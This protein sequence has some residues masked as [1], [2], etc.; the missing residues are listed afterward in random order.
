MTMF[1]YQCQQTAGGTGCREQGVCG[2]DAKTAALQDLLTGW[3]KQIA[4]KR[5]EYRQN[6][7]SSRVVDKFLLEALYVTLTNVN[8]DPKEI[9]RLI[10]LAGQVAQVADYLVTG[11]SAADQRNLEGQL[12]EQDYVPSDQEVDELVEQGLAFSLTY[13]LDD[14][15]PVITGLQEL[16]LYGIRGTAAYT[17]HFYN[18]GHEARESLRLETEGTKLRIKEIRS[19]TADEKRRKDALQKEVKANEEAINEWE[20]KETALLDSLF[21]ELAAVDTLTDREA[22]LASALKIGSLNLNAMELLEQLH[23]SRFDVPWMTAVQTNPVPGK[24]ILVSGHDL[25][26]LYEL[27]VQTKGKEINVYTHGEMLPAHSY[28]GLKKF[29]HLVGHFGTAWQNQRDEFDS[30]PGAILMTSNCIQKPRESYQDYIFTTGPVAWPGVQHISA[31]KNGKKNFSPVIQAALDSPGFF[32]KSGDKEKLT[33]GYGAD[34]VKQIKDKIYRAVERG[35]LRR[36]FVIAGCDGAQEKRNYFTELAEA[37]PEDC[38]ILTCGCGKYRFNSIKFKPMA[39]ATPR[40]WDAGQCNDSW[41]IIRIL[42]DLS[43]EFGKNL[44]DLPVSIFLS[45]YEQKAVAVLLSLLSLNIRNIHIGP[46]VPAFLSP[47]I[48]ALLSENYG[49]KLVSEDPRADLDAVLKSEA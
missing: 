2:K 44:N 18:T 48:L 24:C 35:E 13:R 3:A 32:S 9:A 39:N 36:F 10:C 37:V 26:D 45:W 20:S 42:K 5:V 49:L 7:A 47:E 23:H 11:I 31:D 34:A 22:L 1:C 19:R 41:S 29:T 4:A 12:Q 21:Q 8:F 16:V 46:T 14:P 30:F 27:L 43:E 40:L 17:W 28:P 25:S 6:G 38:V 33:V 15:G